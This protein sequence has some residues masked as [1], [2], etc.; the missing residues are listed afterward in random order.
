VP[1]QGSLIARNGGD[2]RKGV[3][4]ALAA[5]ALLPRLRYPSTV[6]E[7]RVLMDL[8]ESHR[9][10]DDFAAAVQTFE[11]AY[12]SLVALG[13]EN[14]E[15]AGT[16]FNNWALALHFLGQ[17]LKSEELFRRAIR[18][19]S[20]DGTDAHVSPMLHTNLARS[21]VALGRPVEAARYAELAYTRARAA[22]DEVV[23]LQSLLLRQRIYILAGDYVRAGQVSVELESRMA[24]LL[25]PVSSG[26][27]SH[28][29]A[30]SELA[31]ARG[32]ARGAAAA[33]DQAVAI[34]EAVVPNRDL[35]PF[36]LRGRAEILLKLNRPEEARRDA[37][38]AIALYQRIVSPE[39]PSFYLGL[40]YLALGR[41]LIAT[42]EP[43][44]AHRALASALEHL[45]PTL[46]PDS[47][48]ARAAAQLAAATVAAKGK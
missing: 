31:L 35:L 28:A 9:Q 12:A 41:A 3:E 44:E 37:A 23:I 33:A 29:L 2:P 19:S 27:A 34:G 48:P 21:L 25:P 36:L 40:A 26:Y 43:D 14:T 7:L 42:A 10:I 47:P 24:K 32:D 39:T 20:A 15:T 30:R 46:G 6:L 16:L 38:R 1:L 13:R 4:R 17:P 8:A 45:R 11:R 5:Q 22:G 18:I